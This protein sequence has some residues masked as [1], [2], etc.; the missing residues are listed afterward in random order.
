MH[1]L[2]FKQARSA[3]CQSPTSE[4]AWNYLITAIEC[5][6]EGLIGRSVFLLAVGEV[7]KFMGES[8]R[9]KELV[10][11]L[12][13]ASAA[14]RLASTPPQRAKSRP[15]QALSACAKTRWNGNMTGNG[16]D[17]ENAKHTQRLR[18]A[19]IS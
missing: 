16:S 8:S 11:L 9:A 4:H 15:T 7:A 17:S 3:Y 12:L 10:E 13:L 1:V 14:I 6:A 5:A 18:A 19:D 2:T